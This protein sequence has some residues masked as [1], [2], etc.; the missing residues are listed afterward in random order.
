ML[1]QM[2]KMLRL[3]NRMTQKQVANLLNV[4]RSTYTYYETGKIKP[5]IDTLVKLCCIFDVSMDVLTQSE[6][7]NLDVIK[8]NVEEYLSTGE[9]SQTFASLNRQ[10]QHI[11]LLFRLCRNKEEAIE[12]LKELALSTD[13]E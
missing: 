5:S 1:H 4:D 8:E 10:E 13:D 6:C 7:G 9:N 2:L 11:L 12:K 3:N